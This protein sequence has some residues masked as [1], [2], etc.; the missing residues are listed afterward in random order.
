MVVWG[1]QLGEVISRRYQIFDAAGN[2]LL[3]EGGLQIGTGGQN[4]GWVNVST[5]L[6][7]WYIIWSSSHTTIWGQKSAALY[8]LGDGIQI[9]QPHP[10]ITGYMRNIKLEWPWLTWSWT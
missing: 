6:G 9:T 1:E 3:P 7:Y 10:T 5:S 4:V 2:I 8:A